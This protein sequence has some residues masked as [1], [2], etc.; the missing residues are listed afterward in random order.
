MAFK[1]LSNFFRSTFTCK[2]CCLREPETE[3]VSP[4]PVRKL[5]AINRLKPVPGQTGGTK[6]WFNRPNMFFSP[7]SLLIKLNFTNIIQR[8][9]K[10]YIEY[11]CSFVLSIMVNE[12]NQPTPRECVNIQLITL[13]NS[14]IL[15]QN[16][17][18]CGSD[19]LLETPWKLRI[20]MQQLDTELIAF[21]FFFDK[22]KSFN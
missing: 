14:L 12:G 13:A 18:K 15:S 19:A 10:V 9:L 1:I 3:T 17:Q 21:L 6:H 4:A 16:K 20:D 5:G 22:N 8:Y 11:S 7:Q 2:V